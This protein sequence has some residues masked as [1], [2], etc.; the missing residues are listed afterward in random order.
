MLI[1][2]SLSIMRCSSLIYLQDTGRCPYPQERKSSSHYEQIKKPL[3]TLCLSVCSD[4][5]QTC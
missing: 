1:A 5:A 2:T 3:L 4:M